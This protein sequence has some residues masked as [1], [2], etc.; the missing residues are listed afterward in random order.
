[1]TNIPIFLAS[2]DN[3]APFV[4]TTIASICYNTKS[5]I[6]FYVLE[7]DISDFHK[8]QIESL[9]SKFSNFS[10]EF[11]QVKPDLYK[12][13]AFTLS[14]ISLDMYSRFFMFELKPNL[15]KAIYIDL[16]VVVL[17]DIA[18]LYNEDL[19]GN[20]LGA[21]NVNLPKRRKFNYIY[22]IMQI[23]QEHL[24][25]NSGV[26]LFDAEKISKNFAKEMFELLDKY[27]KV[28]RFGDQDT[29]NK[30][31]AG[32]YKTLSNKYNFTNSHIKNGFKEQ[33]IIVRHFEGSKKPWNSNRWYRGDIMKNFKDWWFFAEM[34]P[35]YSGIF[36]EFVA[37][38]IEEGKVKKRCFLKKVFGIK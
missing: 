30:Y 21:I 37:N 5:F 16:D 20:A 34:T 14:H 3:Y 9:K 28:V 19:G 8:T 4:A 22:K 24:Y 10:V 18:D 29:L 36:A 33:N 6:D 12:D 13:F 32:N 35:F 15:K 31:F 7:S 38:K 2:N 11:L 23:P 25:F 17:G 26:L 1:M 27:K